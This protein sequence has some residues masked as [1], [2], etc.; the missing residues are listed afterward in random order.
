MMMPAASALKIAT[1]RLKK[2]R[3]NSGVKKVS[4]K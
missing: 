2:L 3:R 4:A 1:S